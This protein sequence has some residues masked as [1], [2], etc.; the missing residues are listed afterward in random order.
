MCARATGRN[1]AEAAVSPRPDCA[2]RVSGPSSRARACASEIS[3]N[4]SPGLSLT[5]PMAATRRS[6]SGLIPTVV[7]TGSTMRSILTSTPC[8]FSP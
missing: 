3:S 6:G 8:C 5:F 2:A 1:V 7:A 4:R